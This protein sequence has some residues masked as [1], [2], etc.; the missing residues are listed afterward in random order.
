MT[1]S[2]ECLS[3]NDAAALSGAALVGVP[4]GSGAL[5]ALADYP[6][7]SHGD[8]AACLGGGLGLVGAGLGLGGPALGFFGAFLGLNAIGLDIAFGIN[9]VSVCW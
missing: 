9:G 5:R 8:A 4:M 1:S 2:S 7:C 6:A 3:W